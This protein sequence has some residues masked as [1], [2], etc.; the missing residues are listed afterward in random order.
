M[1]P[2]V[3]QFVK[4]GKDEGI[5]SDLHRAY[6]PDE[7]IQSEVIPEKV[8]AAS[9]PDRVRKP[10][11]AKVVQ[12]DI[13]IWV[14]GLV[15]V[16][17]LVLFVV[18][19]LISCIFTFQFFVDRAGVVAASL[20]VILIVGTSNI[21]QTIGLKIIKKS[22]LLGIVM[23]ILGLSAMVFSMTNTVSALYNG[24]SAT[25]IAQQV[26]EAGSGQREIVQQSYDLALKA[27]Q[28]SD[29]EVSQLQAT[30]DGLDIASAE[31]RAQRTRLNA[32]KVY[33]DD[34][35]SKL[36]S[37]T[38]ELRQVVSSAPVAVRGTF[39]SFIAK[40]FG[41]SSDQVEFGLGIYPSLSADLIGPIAFSL[42]LFF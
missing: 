38:V 30:I 3:Q 10:R 8:Q 40:L 13:P 15:K 1:T 12:P 24:R 25:V 18:S 20:F 39:E 41:V 37:I 7:V 5:K 42:F 31:Y 4:A 28:D 36:D 29:Y 33:R 26:A 17:S 11:A 14:R 22:P 35:K 21:F 19:V 16:S 27:Y 34:L 32:A 23:F 9:I 6:F 2:A